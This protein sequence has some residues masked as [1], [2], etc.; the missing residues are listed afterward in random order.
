MRPQRLL[1][2][3]RNIAHF[4]TNVWRASCTPGVDNI[5]TIRVMNNELKP[6]FMVVIMFLQDAVWVAFQAMTT[7]TYRLIL[8]VCVC[9]TKTQP[10][11][12]MSV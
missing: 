4:N 1:L 9:Q 2:L 10:S 6:N 11:L 7:H 12:Y 5:N 3:Y 8:I